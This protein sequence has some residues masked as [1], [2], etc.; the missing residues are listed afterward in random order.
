ML[1]HWFQ[2]GKGPPR[3]AVNAQMRQDKGTEQPRPHCSLVVSGVALRLRAFVMAAIICVGGIQASQSM[4]RH[5]PQCADIYHTFSLVRGQRALRKRHCKN[6][7]W[8]QRTIVAIQTVD[9]I[10]TALA[11]L[12]PESRERLFHAFGKSRVL[13]CRLPEL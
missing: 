6:L 3:V 11:F 2:K 12:V 9:Y 1:G 5:Q 10:K 8:P 7:I 13:L 4:W